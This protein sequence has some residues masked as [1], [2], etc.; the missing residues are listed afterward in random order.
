METQVIDLMNNERT[1]TIAAEQIAT[2]GMFRHLKIDEYTARLT[3]EARAFFY[4]Q[5]EK[6]Q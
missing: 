1:L 5:L 3:P 6:H 2:N 4:H